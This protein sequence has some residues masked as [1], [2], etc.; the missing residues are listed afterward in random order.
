MSVKINYNEL[1]NSSGQTINFN[2]ELHNEFHPSGNEISIENEFIINEKNN[3]INEVVDFDKVQ[4]TPLTDNGEEIKK[5]IYKLRFKNSIG[6][7]SGDTSLSEIGFNNDDIIFFKNSYNQSILSLLFYDSIE[8]NENILLDN[9]TLFPDIRDNDIQQYNPVTPIFNTSEPYDTSN[10]FINIVRDP[11]NNKKLN[12]G[13]KLYSNKIKP[14]LGL[15]EEKYMRAIFSN[16]KNGKQSLFMSKPTA[17]NITEIKEH[18]FVKYSFIKD[19]VQN[20]F[21]Y[22]ID[23]SQN[24]VSYDPLTQTLEI[25][26]YELQVL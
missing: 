9:V 25:I 14:L 16:S 3:S 5:I 20:K 22:V 13:F 6:F 18:I 12:E 7:P 4:F 19:V 26:L 2:F 17:Y 15:V 8:L 1:L 21:Y 24:N 11:Y 23:T 10:L